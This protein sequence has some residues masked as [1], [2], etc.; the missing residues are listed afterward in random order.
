MEKA[1]R[2]VSVKRGKDSREYTL[3]S[4]GGAGG[5]HCLDLARSLQI[6]TVLIPKFAST[7]SAYGMMNANKNTVEKVV[8][9]EADSM[10]GLRC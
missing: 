5:L 10:S 1:L 7:L 6:E 9:P 8:V 2:F 4:F 3:V